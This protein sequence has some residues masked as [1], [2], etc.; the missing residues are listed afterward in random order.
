[1]VVGAVAANAL[2]A[3]LLG[4]ILHV[5]RPRLSARFDPGFPADLLVIHNEGRALEA[6]RLVLDDRFVHRV[7]ALSPGTRTFELRRL[8]VGPDGEPPA[9]DYVPRRLRIVQPR[10]EVI[11]EVRGEDAAP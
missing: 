10:R 8:F 7:D 9:P 3:L 6:A 4:A 5:E 1:V 2:L 11:L